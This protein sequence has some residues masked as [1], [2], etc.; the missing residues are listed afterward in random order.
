MSSCGLS[1]L[2]TTEVLDEAEVGRIEQT[3]GRAADGMRDG[4][5]LSSSFVSSSSGEP[6]RYSDIDRVDERGIARDQRHSLPRRPCCEELRST[7]MNGYLIIQLICFENGCLREKLREKTY[8]KA[9]EIS[10]NREQPTFTCFLDFVSG[11]S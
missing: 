5:C 1:G 3:K 11:P 7:V 10:H 4:P 6:R 8:I 2:S 9:L